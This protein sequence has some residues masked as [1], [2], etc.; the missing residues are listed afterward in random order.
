MFSFCAFFASNTFATKIIVTALGVKT[1]PTTVDSHGTY[2]FNCDDADATCGRI[3]IETA[4]AVPA[5]G[6]PTTLTTFSQLGQ[7]DF[8][9]S[10]GYLD[11]SQKLLQDGT[12]THFVSLSDP[13]EQ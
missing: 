2:T 12:T 7:P 1:G 9:V 13:Q 4:S 6:D 5:P 11:M 8:I 10:G 3:I